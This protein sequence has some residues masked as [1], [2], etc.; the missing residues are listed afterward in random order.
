MAGNCPYYSAKKCANPNGDHNKDCSWPRPDYA[1]C[2][3]YVLI[4]DPTRG[5][6]QVRARFGGSE[7]RD[8]SP[9]ATNVLGEVA[10]QVGGSLSGV[11]KW[12]IYGKLNLLAMLGLPAAAALAAF[13]VFGPRADTLLTVF[14]LNLVVTLFGGLF[15]ALL[16]R[17]ARK[18]GGKGAAIALW[19]SVIPAAFGA[20]WYLWRAVS[21]EEVA[22]GREYLAGPQYLLIMVVGLWV[23]AWIAGRIVRAGKAGG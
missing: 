4:T 11:L 6:A 23:V 2:S 12:T 20:A 1:A 21:P 9:S 10:A 7:G 3:V 19:P 5:M 13:L 8:A 17:G 15:A 14:G 22:P 16:L 18:A